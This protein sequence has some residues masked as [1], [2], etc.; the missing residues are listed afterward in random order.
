MPRSQPNFCTRSSVAYYPPLSQ[1]R[2]SPEI[3][4]DRRRW[5]FWLF[6]ARKRYNLCVLNYIITSNHIHLLVLEHGR[7]DIAKSIQ[8]I[9]GRTAQ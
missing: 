7:G 6:E 3:S 9:A 1:K 4:R 2:I 5:R 8:L